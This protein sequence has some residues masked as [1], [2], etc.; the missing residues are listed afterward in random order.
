[1]GDSA[2]CVCT[3]LVLGG[4]FPSL[5]CGEDVGGLIEGFFNCFGECFV[6]LFEFFI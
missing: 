5:V 2:G 4:A 1:M 6:F 3:A